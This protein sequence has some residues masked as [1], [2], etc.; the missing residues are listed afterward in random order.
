MMAA[1]VP[2]GSDTPGFRNA[3]LR[4]A[5]DIIP[6]WTFISVEDTIHIHKSIPVTLGK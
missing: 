3:P 2:I 6:R 1:N 4:L 5:P